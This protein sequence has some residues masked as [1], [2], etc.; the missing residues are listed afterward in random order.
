MR[1]VWGRD[2][3]AI[4]TDPGAAR[5]LPRLF[6]EDARFDGLRPRSAS[7]ANAQISFLPA[8]LPAKRTLTLEVCLGIKPVGGVKRSALW[9]VERA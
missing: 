3:S 7:I 4:Q 1:I 8:Q 9:F 2:H 6:L 5:L